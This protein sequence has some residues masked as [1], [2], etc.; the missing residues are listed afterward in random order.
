MNFNSFSIP[1]VLYAVLLF[2]SCNN[3][4]EYRVE[5]EFEE[6]V[7]RFENEASK[8]NQPLN[9]H[10]NGLIIEFADLKD[11]QAGLCHY[12]NPI[13]IEIDRTYWKA[14][15]LTKGADYMKENLL[16]HELGHGILKRDHLNTMLENGDWKSI[17]CGGDKVDNRPW[18]INYRGLRRDYYVDEL[19]NES[20]S[21]PDFMNMK[22]SVDTSGYIQQKYLSFDSEKTTDSGWPMSDNANYNISIDNKRLK[23][24]S[25]ID[26]PYFIFTETTVDVQS[27]FSFQA[28][29]QCESLNTAGQYGLVLGINDST[30]NIEYFSIN[31]NQK[32]Y[33]GNRIW[34]SYY[35]ELSKSVIKSGTINKLFVLKKGTMLYYFI[36]DVYV[37]CSEIEITESGKHFG[38]IVPS[39]GTVWLNDMRISVKNTLNSKQFIN[40]KQTDLKFYIQQSNK[41]F[42]PVFNQ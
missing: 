9:L 35:T 28:E 21:T 6:Y 27:D 24:Q 30:Q 7:V 15:S 36:N 29:I 23:F 22:L 19:F 3:E 17:M 32:M 25:K 20:T 8:R 1:F 41:D 10:N 14:I 33:V 40:Q 37:Y 16:F 31:N 34:Y 18:N 12:E 11:N 26:Y 4:N 39:K 38:F 13:R 42:K 2:T 5:E